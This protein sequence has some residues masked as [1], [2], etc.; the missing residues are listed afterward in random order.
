MAQESGWGGGDSGSVGQ[1]RAQL[2]TGC[3]PQHLHKRDEPT[4]HAGIGLHQ[5]W[6]PLRENPARAGGGGTDEFAH[7]ERQ[8]HIATSTR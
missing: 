3:Q 5:P 4:G 8:D 1:S 6:E 7:R 2:S